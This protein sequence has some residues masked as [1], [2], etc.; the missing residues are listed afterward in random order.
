VHLARKYNGEWMAAA[1]PLPFVMDG[2]APHA[3]FRPFEGTLTRE[4]LIVI[5]SPYTPAES[6]ISRPILAGSPVARP[7]RDLVDE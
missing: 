5:A 3:G 7:P 2:W 4:G 6:F 1:G